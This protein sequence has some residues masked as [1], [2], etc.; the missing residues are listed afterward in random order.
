MNFTH[1][2]LFFFLSIHV[3]QRVSEVF[4]LSTSVFSGLEQTCLYKSYIMFV[5]EMSTVS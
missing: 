5:E 2:L 1:L 3:N 4:C